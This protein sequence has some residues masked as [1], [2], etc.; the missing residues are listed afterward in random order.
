MSR[1]DEP[2]EAIPRPTEVPESIDIVYRKSDDYRLYPAT[3]ARGGV[4]VQNNM[5]MDFIV[6]YNSD[7][8]SETFSVEEDGS[9]GEKID[10]DH[11]PTIIREKL[12]G[13]SM[14]Q[15]RALSVASWIISSLMGPEISEDDI[16]DLVRSEYPDRFGDEGGGDQK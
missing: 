4:Q 13:I 14:R 3:G 11:E 8:N 7:P 15:D 6:E 2:E 9:L 16:T 5:K 12:V 1:E 10:D